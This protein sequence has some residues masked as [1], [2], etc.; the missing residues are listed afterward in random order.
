MTAWSYVEG[1]SH[2]V[3]GAPFGGVQSVES[4]SLSSGPY[5]SETVYFTPT[6]YA[7]NISNATGAPRTIYVNG[8]FEGHWVFSAVVVHS[9][10]FVGYL[11][12]ANVTG[13]PIYI[14]CFRG[15]EGFIGEGGAA[16]ALQ[17]KNFNGTIADVQ[18]YNTTL[19]PGAIQQLYT[20]GLPPARVLNLGAG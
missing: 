9:G 2:T 12:G 16:G 5:A 20:A 1:A 15:T 10:T 11:N 18:I 8:A 13:N 4:T 17:G 6:Q 14:G 3:I 19:S 7:L